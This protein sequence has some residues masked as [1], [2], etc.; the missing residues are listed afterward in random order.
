[1]HLHR[2]AQTA[3]I[4]AFIWPVA[5]VAQTPNVDWKYYARIPVGSEVDQ[6]FYNAGDVVQLPDGHIEVWTKG[7]LDKDVDA[8]EDSKPPNAL[9][10]QAS[11]GVYKK[12]MN[13]YD[14]PYSTLGHW[15]KKWWLQIVMAEEIANIGK[16]E[17]RARVLY[18]IDCKNRMMRRLSIHISTKGQVSSNDHPTEWEHTAPETPAEAL[19]ALVCRRPQN[20]SAG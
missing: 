5:V 8:I 2:V 17:P 4:H 9:Y 11:D 6:L 10:K 19:E 7:L 12:M 13:Q 3:L 14:P 18:E 15:D 1:M 20:P 16:T